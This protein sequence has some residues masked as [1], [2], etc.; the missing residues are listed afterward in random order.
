MGGK[1]EIFQGFLRTGYELTLISGDPKGLF[2]PPVILRAYDEWSFHSG[3]SH[4]EFRG[5]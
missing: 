4:R 5:S 2:G 1:K 3:P